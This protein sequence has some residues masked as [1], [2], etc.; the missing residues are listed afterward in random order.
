MAF[1]TQNKRLSVAGPASGSLFTLPLSPDAIPYNVNDRR[2]LSGLY[3]FDEVLEPGVLT[4]T[5]SAAITLTVS[6]ST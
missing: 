4:V 5:L 3:R 6:L 2:H 1:D